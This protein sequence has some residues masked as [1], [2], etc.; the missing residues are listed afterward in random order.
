MSESDEVYTVEALIDILHTGPTAA[1]RKLARTALRAV[2]AALRAREHQHHF[3]TT[4]PD[5]K[6]SCGLPYL[7]WLARQGSNLGPRR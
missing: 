6:C 4:R 3:A 2:D 7:Q 1:E 5:E